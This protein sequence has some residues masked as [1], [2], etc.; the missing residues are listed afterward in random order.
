MPPDEEDLSR[1]S[2]EQI[3]ELQR[4]NCVFCQ[5][6]SGKIPSRKVFEDEKC[7]AVL[8]ISP[9]N[10]GHMLLLPKDHYSVMPQLPDELTGHLF[11]VAKHLSQAAL[12]AFKLKGT[13]IFV[14]NGMA[15]GQKAPHVLIHVIPR[16]FEDGIDLSMP[17]AKVD[18]KP[19]R[20][21]LAKML[22]G[23]RILPSFE[24]MPAANAAAE[25]LTEAK[26]AKADAEIPLPDGKIAKLG[27][28]REKGYL[29][30]IDK[31]GDVAMA[32]MSR[33]GKKGIRKKKKIKVVYVARKKTAV[34]K[35]KATL[36]KKHLVKEQ[37]KKPE[38][39]KIQKKAEKANLDDISR[40]FR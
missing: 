22:Q 34:K 8:D 12:K 17:V 26:I 4:K 21:P 1:L 18:Q 31:E 2:P 32:Q 24:K 19:L 33:G 28:K 20:E 35:E 7:V 39:A 23:K 10:L 13:T 36:A 37:G 38:P 15:A 14:A 16:A 30:Y 5:I 11:N 25:M 40:L 3:E 29:Y 6:A 9:A 27:I